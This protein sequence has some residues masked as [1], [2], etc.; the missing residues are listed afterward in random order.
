MRIPDLMSFWQ[1]LLAIPYRMR[2]GPVEGLF[3][4]LHPGRQGGRFATRLNLGLELSVA[5]TGP[6]EKN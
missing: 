1:D 3:S 6:R 4:Y 2:A 5:F